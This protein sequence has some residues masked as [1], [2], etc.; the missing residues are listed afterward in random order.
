[1][2]LH[3]EVAI[4]RLKGNAIRRLTGA[5]LALLSLFAGCPLYAQPA[6][7]S[8]QS[9]NLRSAVPSTNAYDYSLGSTF[10]RILNQTASTELYDS[11]TI[12]TLKRMQAEADPDWDPAGLDAELTRQVAE[13]A[14]SIQAGRSLVNIV[15][16][17]DLR[18][19][20]REVIRNF[21]AVQ[22]A[23]RLTVRNNGG[24][25]SFKKRGAGKKILE[26]GVEFNLRRGLDPQLKIGNTMRFRYDY[27]ASM[28]LLEYGFSF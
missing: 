1:M 4:T 24:S 18:D 26:L 10:D 27:D 16:K 21:S 19:L 23:L 12:A 11:F 5:L 28:P 2:T 7:P 6:S 13:R 20:Y 22:D 9:K 8:P 25:F 15:R 14:F 17:S 3:A